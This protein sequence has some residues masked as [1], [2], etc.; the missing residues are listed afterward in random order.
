MK[1]NRSPA[2]EAA[3]YLLPPEAYTSQA[4]FDREQATL[5]ARNWQFA[6]M[7][8]KAA[9][10][11]AYV[12]LDAG[13]EPLVIVRGHDGVLRCFYNLCRHRGVRL[14][15][16]TGRLESGIS[17]FYHRW[18]Y[19]LEGSLKALPQPEQFPGLCR[20]EL[21]LQAASLQVWNGM[22]F[23]NPLPDAPPLLN[24]LGA[25]A[26]HMDPWRPG[27]LI[28]IEHRRMTIRANW[29]LFIENHIDGYH[30]WYLHAD[31]VRG[32]DH[33]KQ[34]WRPVG[35]H[36][37]FYEPPLEPGVSPDRQ[38]FGTPIIEGFDET[39]FGSTVWW[40]MPNLAGAAGATFW[41]AIR[42]IP[43]SPGETALEIRTRIGG[44]PDQPGSG[45]G[46]D[47]IVDE[48]VR[49]VESIQR[50]MSSAAFR[51]GPLSNDFE[52]SIQTFHKNILRLMETGRREV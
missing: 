8:D 28:P 49:A 25:M 26:D 6:C 18:Q 32:L 40:V 23:V 42:I 5:F 45:G 3:R 36:W 11:G 1:A 35:P 24:W 50:A 43:I 19:S 51:V 13:R 16:G 17:C 47:Q 7:D 46:L 33:P 15:E 27:E 38:Q 20:D 4:W 48:D 29:K 2:P 10:L 21:G 44:L 9:G 37:A 30:L 31:S 22:V 39:R 14:L 12:T 52:R 41:S 34:T